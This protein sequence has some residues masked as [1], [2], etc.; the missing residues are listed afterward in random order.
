MKYIIR[1]SIPFILSIILCFIFMDTSKEETNMPVMSEVS[2]TKVFKT[3]IFD[4]LNDSE[5]EASL[6][7]GIVLKKDD[8]YEVIIGIL[9]SESNIERMIQYLNDLNI[10]YYIEDITLPLTFNDILNKY[11]DLMASSTSYVAFFQLNKK[12]LERYRVL[13]ES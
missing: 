7:K 12:I 4:N 2:S 11:E 6:K 9:K 8:K 5:K 10:Y 3:G 1:T 13:Y